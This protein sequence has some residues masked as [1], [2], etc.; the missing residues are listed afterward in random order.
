MVI[1][2][3]PTQSL[4][5]L[6]RPLAVDVRI[7]T[8]QHD[9]VLPLMIALQC[10]TYSLGARRKARSPRTNTLDRHSAFTELTQRSA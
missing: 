2:Q 1:A 7:A 6:H 10:S 9:V 5:T 3:E 8:E 4:A